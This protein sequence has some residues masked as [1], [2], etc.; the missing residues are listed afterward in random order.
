MHMQIVEVEPIRM[1]AHFISL[2]YQF[3][4][5]KCVQLLKWYHYRKITMAN[6]KRPQGPIVI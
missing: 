5:Q 6:K 1:A 4:L 3:G 2:V